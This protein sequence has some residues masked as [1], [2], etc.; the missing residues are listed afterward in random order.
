MRLA[1]CFIPAV[2]YVLEVARKPGSFPDFQAARAKVEELLGS[3]GRMA[4]TLGVAASEFQ[5]ARFAVCAWMDEIV[6]GSAWEGKAQWLHQ[7]L[8]RAVY[9]TV[10]AGEEYFERLDGVLARMDKD[11]SFSAPG[12]KAS[13]E[14]LSF[15]GDEEQPAGERCSLAAGDAAFAPPPADDGAGIGVRG[16]LEVFGLTMMLGFQ[17]RYF[18]PDDQPML[19]S[20]RQKVI[21]AALGGP[22]RFGADRFGRDPAAKLFPKLYE[23][24]VGAS[25][26]RRRFWRGLDWVDMVTLGVPVLAAAVMYYAYSFLL[27]GALKG[28]LGG[29]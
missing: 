22:E 7:P 25:G 26:G 18:H 28:F 16:V 17:G 11:F 1:D 3:A 21:T 27:S 12:E 8:Q 23:G 19:R 5:D 14:D 15:G 29:P 13:V 4:R 2:T 10:N 9:N 20:L 24:G 6:L